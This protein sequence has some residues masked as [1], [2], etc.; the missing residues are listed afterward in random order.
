M[1]NVTPGDVYTTED[2]H[3]ARETVLL[4]W[5]RLRD[6][7]DIQRAT[8]DAGVPVPAVAAAVRAQDEEFRRVVDL[9]TRMAPRVLPDGTPRAPRAPRPGP[10]PVPGGGG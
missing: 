6:W 7:R 2:L 9:L 4:E 5:R 8:A 1:D 3:R 10:G